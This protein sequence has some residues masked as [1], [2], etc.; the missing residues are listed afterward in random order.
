MT[1]ISSIIDTLITLALGVWFALVGFGVIPPSKDKAKG[2]EWRLKWGLYFKI[3]GIFLILWGGFKI[4]RG[5]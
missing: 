2:E 3:G 1:M 5:L 4:S